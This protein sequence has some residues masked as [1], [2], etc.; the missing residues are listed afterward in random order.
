MSGRYQYHVEPGLSVP[1]NFLAGAGHLPRCGGK[2]R[3]LH[4]CG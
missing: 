4:Y 1:G 3:L 2:R